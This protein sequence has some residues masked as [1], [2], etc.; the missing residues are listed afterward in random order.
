MVQ[1][2]ESHIRR[3]QQKQKQWRAEDVYHQEYVDHD[4]YSRERREGD[5]VNITT[6]QT[7][8]STYVADIISGGT[9]GMIS[10]FVGQP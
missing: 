8:D 2:G 3:Q 10:I 6:A 7:T 5:S 9:A 4:P 1:G